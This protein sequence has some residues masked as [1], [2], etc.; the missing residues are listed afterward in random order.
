MAYVLGFMFADGSLLDTNNSS[1][2]V[3]IIFSNNELEILEE[4]KSA[5][6]SDHKISMR[7]PHII[8]LRGKKYT[9]K[10]HYI[11]RIGNKVMSQDLI[12]L[13]MIHRKSNVMHLPR[14]PDEYFSLFLRGYFDGDGCI[15]LN[16]VKGHTTNRVT[17]IF[18]SGS[19]AFLREIANK[20]GYLL[21]VKP[22]TYYKSMGA[23]NLVS[24]GVTAT[25]I[26]DYMYY[27]LD[28]APYLK[29]KYHKYLE[30]KNNLMGPRVKKAL[31]I[32]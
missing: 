25:K 9:S 24:R 4:I 11:L 28:L 29:R 16:L 8:Q 18:T 5:L 14:V 23:Y 12:L 21:D 10:I 2:T 20:I 30:Y 3:Y 32:N 19:T 7:P 27:N 15:N 1:R 26:L 22:P 13:G 31:G 17:V 6:V